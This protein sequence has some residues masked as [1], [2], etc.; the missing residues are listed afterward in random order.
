MQTLLSEHQPT[1]IW[2][3]NHVNLENLYQDMVENMV[4]HQDIRENFTEAKTRIKHHSLSVCPTLETFQSAWKESF[5]HPQITEQE[6]IDLAYVLLTLAESKANKKT[7][8]LWEQIKSAK[9]NDDNHKNYRDELCLKMGKQFYAK[10]SRDSELHLPRFFSALET[11][12]VNTPSL[13][14]E[15]T[16]LSND[17]TLRTVDN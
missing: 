6:K 17:L 15:S 14:Y 9:Q 7:L 16:P 8:S 10:Q 2:K 5:N 3:E 1:P 11:K 12:F 4:N 13:I